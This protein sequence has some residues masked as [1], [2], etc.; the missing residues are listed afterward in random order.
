MKFLFLQIYTHHIAP[1]FQY[2]TAINAAYCV[3]HGY[4]YKTT[5]TN[6]PEGY[7]FSW[8]KLFAVKEQY[9]N[10]DYIF[11]LDSDAVVMNDGITLE[12]RISN[13]KGDILF[14]E[15][16][17]NGGTLINGG[18]FILK[19]S[20]SGRN[21]IDDIIRF[22]AMGEYKKYQNENYYEQTII[23]KMYETGIYNE[24]VDVFPMNHI[25]SYWRYDYSSND[26]QFIFHFMAWDIIDKTDII[27]KIFYRKFL[28]NICEDLECDY[29]KKSIKDIV[30]QTAEKKK[31]SAEAIIQVNT[32]NKEE[33]KEEIKEENIETKIEEIV[34]EVKK[35]YDNLSVIIP[36]KSDKIDRNRNFNWIYE[37]TKKILPG[38][39]IIIGVDDR[40]TTGTFNKSMAINDAVKKSTKGIILLLDA[41]AFIDASGF[42]EGYELI[43]RNPMVIAQNEVNCLDKEFS[44]KLVSLNVDIKVEDFAKLQPKVSYKCKTVTLAIFFHKANFNK[45][46]GFDERFIGWGCEDDAFYLAHC[47]LFG[48]ITTTNNPAYHIYHS[49]LNEECENETYNVEKNAM[50]EDVMISATN[51]P[52]Y[53]DNVGFVREYESRFMKKSEMEEYIKGL[54]KK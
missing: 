17:W 28:K 19:C 3:K 47:T 40:N 27:K 10:Y 20:D 18:A 23:T 54:E 44:Q 49:R 51:N 2:A 45:M 21:F 8:G 26:G 53:N 41:D 43:K 1:Y 13:M 16:G 7:G 52:H 50:Q 32:E 15:N 6:T 34:E 48:P 29:D 22:S 31:I 9:N 25:N 38:A 36:F 14:S 11:F 4:E 35:T 30:A 39:E 12:D 42:E 5:I 33:I 46:S 37:R 24:I